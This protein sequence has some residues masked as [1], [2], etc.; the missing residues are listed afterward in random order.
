M[1]GWAFV[2][3]CLS[4]PPTVKVLAVLKRKSLSAENSH[5]D[6]GMA[7]GAPRGVAGPTRGS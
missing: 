6:G 4:L 7:S 2:L 1:V 3:C 5:D